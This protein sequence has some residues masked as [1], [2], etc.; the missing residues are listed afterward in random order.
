M[1]RKRLLLLAAAVAILA[2]VGYFLSAQLRPGDAA[3]AWLVFGPTA[4]VRVLVT[5][6]G[7]TITLQPFVGEHP[8]GRK[9][10]FKD[11]GQP[12]EI[13]LA[14]PDGVTSYTIRKCASPV[15][16]T[17]HP[18]KGTPTELFVNVDVNGPVPYGQYSDIP[19]T[20]DL[21][22]APVSHFHGPLAIGALTTNWEVPPDLAFRRGGEATDLQATIGTMDPKRGCWVVVKTHQGADKCLFLD[23]VRP[24][25]DIEF[26]SKKAGDPPIKQRYALDHFC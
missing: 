18:K 14:D 20:A 24:V 6:A 3:Y 15:L 26:P 21:S 17:D 9:E 25:A 5:V 7:D 16:T 11:R 19:L 13:T 2:A 22:T 12:L 4:H 10:Q 23:G 8:R 1:K